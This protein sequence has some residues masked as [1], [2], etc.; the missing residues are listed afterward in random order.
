MSGLDDAPGRRQR[1]RMEAGGD[2]NDEAVE[3]T[4]PAT[5]RP[6]N[7]RDHRDWNLDA[8]SGDQF[9]TIAEFLEVLED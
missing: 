7:Q 1:E 4:A 8:E 9:K 3:R 2:F 6:L 5:M